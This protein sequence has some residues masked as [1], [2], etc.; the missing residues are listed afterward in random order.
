MLLSV[1]DL[2]AILQVPE[3]TVYRWIRDR[4]LPA[5]EVS[6]HARAHPV[7]LLEWLA[8]H[9]VAVDPR[10]LPTDAL[11]SG[12]PSLEAA[13]AAGGI[14]EDISGTT[15]ADALTEAGNAQTSPLPS[16]AQ[17]TEI[18]RSN[19]IHFSRTARAAPNCE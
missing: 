4:G 18:S 19:G 7:D 14:Y 8:D 11:A 15:R 13:I 1:R 10:A 17:I 12:V 2:S 5:R 6:G 16:L 3:S 9:P